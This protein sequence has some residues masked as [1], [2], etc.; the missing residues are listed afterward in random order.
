ML[1]P[2]GAIA[3]KD[4]VVDKSFF[5]A[6]FRSRSVPNKLTEAYINYKLFGLLAQAYY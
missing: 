2:S 1:L 5:P 3:S 4:N 6:Q